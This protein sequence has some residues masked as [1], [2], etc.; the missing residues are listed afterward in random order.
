M[1]F[2]QV[3]VGGT[4]RAHR[5]IY[6]RSR[7]AGTPRAHRDIYHRSRSAGTPRAHR[8]IYH[9]SRSAGTPRAHRD[10][11][12]RSRSAGT[13]TL[14]GPII[15]VEIGAPGEDRTP[16]SSLFRRCY[17]PPTGGAPTAQ[18]SLAHLAQ[19]SSGVTSPIFTI[20]I[21]YGNQNG[22]LGEDR[23]PDPKFRKLVLYPTELRAR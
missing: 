19:R 13:P 18:D 7:S 21:P 4:P 11:Y 2:R 8:D 17:R 20:L 22:A 5:D 23:T 16:L 12:H 15:E 14:L 1:S 10:I 6:H 3:A 9:R